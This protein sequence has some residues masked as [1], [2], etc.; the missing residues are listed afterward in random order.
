M[1]LPLENECCG[2][3]ACAE[4]CP[5]HAI[6]LKEDAHGFTRTV[7]DASRCVECGLCERVCPQLCRVPGCSDAPSFFAARLRDE[8]GLADVSSGGVFWAL[9]QVVLGHGGIVYGASREGRDVV[10][11]I[12]A[13]TIDEAAGMRRSKYLLSDMSGCYE[14][15]RRDLSA[16]RRVLFTGTGCQVA[17]V[18]RFLPADADGL[19]T[20]EVVCHG[21][22]SALAW[23]S[24]VSEHEMSVGKKVVDVICRD[25]SA[26]WKNNH[27]RFLYDDDTSFAEP[28]AQNLFHFAYL[29]G[30]ILRGACCTCR[31]AHLPRVADLSLAD[32]WGYC[33]NVIPRDD[34]GVSLVA[35]NT[36]RGRALVEE[37]SPLLL[38][39]PATE[40][41]ARSSCRHMFNAPMGNACRSE[42][43]GELSRDG[44]AAAFRRWGIPLCGRKKKSRIGGLLVA[45][46][47]RF[48]RR[49]GGRT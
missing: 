15:L 25:K 45:L 18:R 39:E 22:P 30:L 27:Y 23:R 32:F 41:E 3:G 36:E 24:Y 38:V 19:V 33:G 21:V 34:R 46:A 4:A 1:K 2:C 8:K 17:A 13:E 16:G 49:L 14:S 6:A 7:V 44:F 11:H 29:H 42:F 43:L 12:R 31:Y 47:N 10:R 28:S 26:G 37:A 5:R 9:A 20:A 40:A 48:C 35:A